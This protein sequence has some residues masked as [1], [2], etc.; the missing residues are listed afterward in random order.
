M[1]QET[2]KQL[3]EM[4]KQRAAF[5]GSLTAYFLVNTFLVVVWYITSGRGGKY[6]WPIWPI[7]GWGLGITIQYL[8]AY[9]GSKFFSAEKEYEKLKKK[10]SE[11]QS[12]T[13]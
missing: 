1:E 5:K 11:S 8:N 6:F 2:D 12:F 13:Q 7:L 10:S 4:A 9:H 3:W